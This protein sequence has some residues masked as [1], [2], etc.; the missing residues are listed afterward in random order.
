MSQ[1]GPKI[2]SYGFCEEGNNEVKKNKGNGKVNFPL[3]III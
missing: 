2:D 3:I 1:E